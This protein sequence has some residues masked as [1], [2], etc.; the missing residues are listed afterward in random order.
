MDQSQAR[1]SFIDSLCTAEV[2]RLANAVFGTP[3]LSMLSQQLSATNDCVAQGPSFEQQDHQRSAV[4]KLLDYR[5]WLS[6]LDQSPQPLIEFIHSGK[7]AKSGRIKLGR[8]YEKLWQFFLSFNGVT[9]LIAANLPAR[10]Q[11]ND[12]GEFDLIYKHPTMG[13]IHLEIACKYYL[14]KDQKTE[15]WATWLGPGKTDRL[16]LKLN[17]TLHKQINLADQPMA[18]EQ[19]FSHIK[20]QHIEPPNADN[21]LSKQLYIGGRLFYRLSAS[22]ILAGNT[23]TT[24]S[25]PEHLPSKH[26]NGHWLLLSEWHKL[27]N[28]AAEDKSKIHYKVLEK[29]QWLDTASGIMR[30]WRQT[31][32]TTEQSTPQ[33]TEPEFIRTPALAVYSGEITNGQAQFCFIVGDDWLSV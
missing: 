32:E 14:A 19:L 7:H 5:D 22:D 24:L 26:P 15:D 17:H 31:K 30:D 23:M 3:L 2:R 28:S 16:D 10:S 18:C 25:Q 13:I 1:D 12:L 9:Q 11:S 29:P 27:I 21:I 8:Y 20:N 33:H 6:A 4:F